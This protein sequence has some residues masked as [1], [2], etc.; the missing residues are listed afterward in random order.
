MP[1]YFALVDLLPL[2][3]LRVLVRS[4]PRGTPFGLIAL[5]AP[6]FEAA[7]LVIEGGALRCSFSSVR[8]KGSGTSPYTLE[9]ARPMASRSERHRTLMH[10][11][12]F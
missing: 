4:V 8:H 2:R 7:G 6:Y 3:K 1:V 10:P 9:H 5:E 11:L 12:T